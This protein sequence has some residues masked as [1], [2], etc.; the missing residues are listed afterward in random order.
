MNRGWI[1]PVSWMDTEEPWV[2]TDEPWTNTSELQIAT[3]EQ[4]TCAENHEWKQMNNGYS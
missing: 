3:D 1:Q 4:W 2:D